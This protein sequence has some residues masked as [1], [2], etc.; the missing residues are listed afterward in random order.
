MKSDMNTRKVRHIKT[1]AF[2]LLE[3]VSIATFDASI[4]VLEPFVM[5]IALPDLTSKG[6]RREFGMQSAKRIMVHHFAA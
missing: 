3:A 6:V 2:H 5:F 4:Q 1:S